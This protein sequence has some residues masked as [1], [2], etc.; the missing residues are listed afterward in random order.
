MTRYYRGAGYFVEIKERKRADGSTHYDVLTSQGEPYAYAGRLIDHFGGIDA[1][2]ENTEYSDLT[3]EELEKERGYQ[4][5]RSVEQRKISWNTNK[6]A[7]IRLNHQSRHDYAMLMASDC[8]E[9]TTKNICTILRHCLRHAEKQDWGELPK[10]SIPYSVR[11]FPNIKKSTGI[12]FGY[13]IT[14]KTAEPIDFHGT[15]QN[16]FIL[17]RKTMGPFKNVDYEDGLK[18]APPNGINPDN[19]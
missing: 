1:F 13:Y 12:M 5:A 10:L 8:N 4:P 18:S 6:E 19:R 14:A 15:P 3:I 9:A 2:L 11:A 7:I 17:G 16:C